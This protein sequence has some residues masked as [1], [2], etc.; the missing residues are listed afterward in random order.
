MRMDTKFKKYIPMVSVEEKIWEA[1][2]HMLTIGTLGKGRDTHL[3]QRRMSIALVQGFPIPQ[4]E[5]KMFSRRPGQFRLVSAESFNP[6]SQDSRY[7]I[8]LFIATSI[9]GIG[10]TLPV[11]PRQYSSGAAYTLQHCS[12]TSM[13]KE[14]SRIYVAGVVKLDFHQ[15]AKRIIPQLT[16]S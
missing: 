12:K 5:D 16:Q 14:L 9:D 10:D 4:E 3:Y 1:E 8:S 11:T 2:A 7:I 13:A 15:P 6:K